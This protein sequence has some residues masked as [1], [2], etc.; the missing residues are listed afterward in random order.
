MY[1]D[2]VIC[3]RCEEVVFIIMPTSGSEGECPVCGYSGRDWIG[4]DEYEYEDE[5]HP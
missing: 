3:P 5:D 1:D 4:L 2:R